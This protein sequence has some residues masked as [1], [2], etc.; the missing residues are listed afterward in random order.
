MISNAVSKEFSFFP[1]KDWYT[2]TLLSI[3]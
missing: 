1:V 3:I 2:E